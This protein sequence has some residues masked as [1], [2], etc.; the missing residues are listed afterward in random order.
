M[1]GSWGW[2]V[3]ASMIESMDCP[4]RILRIPCCF[5]HQ[6]LLIFTNVLSRH[7]S[8]SSLTA[9]QLCSGNLF[10]DRST[11]SGILRPLFTLRALQSVTLI[12]SFICVFGDDWL[13]EATLSWPSLRFLVLAPRQRSLNGATL[14]WQG[15]CR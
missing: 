11:A 2:T 1:F 3:S 13:D 10:T 15:Y 12:F 14:R 4:S 5:S 8:V 9:L 7:R 6:A